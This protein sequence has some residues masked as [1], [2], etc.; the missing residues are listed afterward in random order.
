MADV[1][2]KDVEKFLEALMAVQRRYGN[3]LRNVK[4]NRQ[5]DVREL[6][7]RFASKGTSDAD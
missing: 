2:Q 5:E 6:V 4:S 1:D 3:E 7:D